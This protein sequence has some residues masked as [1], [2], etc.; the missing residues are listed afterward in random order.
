[1]SKNRLPDAELTIMKALW[2]I[3]TDVTS[4]QIQDYI[5]TDCKWTNVMVL[6]LLARLV[7]R[8]FVSVEKVG[9]HNKYSPIVNESDYLQIESKSFLKKLH[10]DSLRSLVSS[11]YSGDSIST[12]DLEDLRQFIEERTCESND[13]N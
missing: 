3:G 2:A 13:I 8:D 4:H 1:M 5:K 12:A 7:K 11:L 6:N 10:G 9:T